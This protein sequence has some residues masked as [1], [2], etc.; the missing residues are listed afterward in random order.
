MLSTACQ[1]DDPAFRRRVDRLHALGPRP[2]GEFLAELA[3][4]PGSAG[5]VITTLNRY[6]VIDAALLHDLGGD[7][8][9]VMPLYSVTT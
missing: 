3:A 5:A 9:P 8:W 4:R 7:R 6:A 1:I 2:L